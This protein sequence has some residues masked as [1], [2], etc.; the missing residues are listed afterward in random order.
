M[1]GFTFKLLL[2][3]ILLLMLYLVYKIFADRVAE[4]A[5]M[6]DPGNQPPFQMTDQMRRDEIWSRTGTIGFNAFMLDIK[7]KN[8]VARTAGN[9]SKN[10]T[11]KT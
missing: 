4:I 10:K 9:L 1:K 7:T 11:S 5:G 2:S 3:L 6:N 8:L